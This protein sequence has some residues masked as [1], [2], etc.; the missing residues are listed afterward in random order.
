LPRLS[1]AI[2]SHLKLSE[3][4]FFLPPPSGH[5]PLVAPEIR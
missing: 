1:E 5:H 3:V 4:C 2:S